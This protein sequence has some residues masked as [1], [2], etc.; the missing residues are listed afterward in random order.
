MFN[1]N[2]NPSMLPTLKLDKKAVSLVA[3]SYTTNAANVPFYYLNRFVSFEMQALTFCAFDRY[4]SPTMVVNRRRIEF[5][6]SRKMLPR[7]CT[8]L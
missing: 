3:L 7:T 6:S 8:P 1:A 4:W 2:L 5:W